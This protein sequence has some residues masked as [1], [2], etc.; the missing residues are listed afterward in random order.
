MALERSGGGLLSNGRMGGNKGDGLPSVKPMRPAQPQ[1]APQAPAPQQAPQSAPQPQAPQQPP[2]GAPMPQGQE[3]MPQGE[4]QGQGSGVNDLMNNGLALLHDEQAA[5][6]FE[7]MIA[8][9]EEGAA[10]A[11]V[12]IGKQVLAAHM[13]RGFQPDPAQASDAIMEIVNDIADIGLGNGSIPE[14]PLV[15]G[16]PAGVYAIYAYAAD[17][18]TAAFPEFGQ[19]MKEEIQS[20]TPQDD[21]AARQV[22]AYMKQRK[23]E[24]A[25]G[26]QNQSAQE[27]INNPVSSAGGRIPGAPQ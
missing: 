18:W 11:A 10:T 24:K 22:A 16:V 19:S 27:P 17:Q 7:K 8:Q 9:G 14:Q 4:P 23:Q 21:E 26:N 6:E 12:T 2:Q 1:A 5:P 13:E 25:N 3:G 15:N 20:A